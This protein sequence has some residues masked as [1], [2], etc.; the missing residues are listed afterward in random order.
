MA[1][2]IG[3]ALELVK[4]TTCKNCAARL[5]YVQAEVRE[6]NGHDY[7]GGSEG[8][9]YIKCPRCMKRVTLRAW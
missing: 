5:E 9:E 3:E 4:H 2:V 6:H 1:K 7:T 8:Y